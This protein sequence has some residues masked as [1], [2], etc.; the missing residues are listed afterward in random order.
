VANHPQIKAF[1]EA[2]SMLRADRYWEYRSRDERVEF[3]RTLGDVLIEVCYHLD[4]NEV[5]PLEILE[6][7]QEVANAVVGRLPVKPL[8]ELF[9]MTCLDRRIE[10]L[11]A[12]PDAS[13]DT[14]GRGDGRT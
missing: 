3:L 11:I 13:R 9:L 4:A 8:A 12:E 7:G 2:A 10:Q 1:N 14:V 6:V 5:L